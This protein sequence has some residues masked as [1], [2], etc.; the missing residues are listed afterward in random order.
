[1][2]KQNKKIKKELAIKSTTDNLVL[3]REFTRRAAIESSLPDDF[4]E[5][6]ILAVD[7]ACTNVIK[8]AYKFSPEGDI[9]ISISV[10]S[11]K[12]IISITDSGVHFNPNLIPEPDIKQYHK[13]KKIGGLGMFLM[14]KLMDEV[15]YTSVSGNKNQV[16]LVKYL[17]R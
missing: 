14:K 7:E 6:I 2:N 16:E 12:F 5:K 8:H 1:M 15:R 13:E 17:T 9:F 11:S 10:D 4:T 3:V